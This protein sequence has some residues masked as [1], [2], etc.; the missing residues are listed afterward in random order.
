MPPTRSSIGPL[1]S[2]FIALLIVVGAM[3]PWQRYVIGPINLVSNFGY[4]TSQGQLALLA[5]IWG[6]VLGYVCAF[7]RL[8]EAIY[9]VG[10]FACAAVSIGAALTYWSIDNQREGFQ[11]FGQQVRLT[12]TGMGVY[13]TLAAAIVYLISIIWQIAARLSQKDRVLE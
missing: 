1:T 7:V 3:Q 8:P 5:G 12:Q 11:F 2:A 13:V 10:A 9:F 4:D 6:I